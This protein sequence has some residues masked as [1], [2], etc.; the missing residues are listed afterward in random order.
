M[1]DPEIELAYLRWF[2]SEADFGPADSDVRYYM[3]QQYV[4]DGGV[5]PV[6]YQDQ[7]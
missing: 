2:Y 5:I 1:E 3:N 7:E 4:N 6:A